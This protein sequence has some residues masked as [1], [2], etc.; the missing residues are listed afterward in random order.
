M[1]KIINRVR[2]RNALY[3]LN[4][5]DREDAEKKEKDRL[6]LAVCE[7]RYQEMMVD[8]RYENVW[9]HPLTGA[10]IYSEKPAPKPWWR[11]W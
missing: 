3:W 8:P 6:R 5:W 10:I 11:F 7:K 2:A 9:M 1:G 4:R